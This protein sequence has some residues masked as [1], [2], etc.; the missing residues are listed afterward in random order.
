MDLQLNGKRALV[1]GSTSGIGRAIALTLAAEGAAVIVHGRDAARAKETADAI[2]ARGGR[3]A[4][5]LGDLTTNPDAQRIAEAAETA[6]G[7]IDILVNNAAS[8]DGEPTWTAD[9]PDQWLALY[10]ANVASAVRLIT[11]L[12]P[13]MRTAGWGRVIQ[14]GSAA[15]P[16]PLPMKAAYS[17]TKAA[18]AN[19]TVSL[20]KELTGTG[21]TANTISPGPTATEHFH[22]LALNFAHHHG[23]GDDTTAA[24][25]AL[26]QGPLANPSGRL[27]EPHEIAALTALVASP[28]GASINGANLRIDGALTP[29][30][31]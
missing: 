20:A 2:T 21:V 9:G 3:S 13:P 10:N 26:L 11:A 18:L 22:E 31:N 27:T 25:R 28:L 7:G 1:T 17:A 30:V 15:H 14:I 23:M 19:L 4:I 8:N 6:F 12:T 29:T 5:A 16:F 24:T